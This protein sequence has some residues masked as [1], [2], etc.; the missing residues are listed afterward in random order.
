MVHTHTHNDI[1]NCETYTRSI[2]SQM[3]SIIVMVKSSRGQLQK[4]YRK[5]SS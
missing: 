2:K 1:Q 3:Y 5:N 4:Y